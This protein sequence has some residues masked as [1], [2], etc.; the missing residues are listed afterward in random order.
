MNL[1][2]KEERDLSKV[3]NEYEEAVLE[4]YINYAMMYKRE[5]ASSKEIEYIARN[6]R[7]NPSEIIKETI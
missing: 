5:K 1:T 6:R 3:T 7:H 2:K 4:Q